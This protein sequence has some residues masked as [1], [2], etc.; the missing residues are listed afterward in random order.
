[1]TSLLFAPLLMPQDFD[2]AA[3]IVATAFPLLMLGMPEI[4]GFIQRIMFLVSY[5]WYGKEALR[6]GWTSY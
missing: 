6:L 1:L 4:H 3:A 5:L 2:L